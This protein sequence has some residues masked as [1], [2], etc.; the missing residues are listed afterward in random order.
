MID[1]GD[2]FFGL[3]PYQGF[4]VEI[5]EGKPSSEE[6]GDG[7]GLKT[8]MQKVRIILVGFVGFDF[9]D[10]LARKLFLFGVVLLCIWRIGR[11][12]TKDNGRHLR[13]EQSLS[14]LLGFSGSFFVES[15]SL[16]WLVWE[17][18]QLGRRRESTQPLEEAFVG[19]FVE[20]FW[21][22]N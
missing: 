7:D 9:D 4:G 1:K 15:P 14:F 20:T 12:M 18:K 13:R 11:R 17:Y 19:P 3:K 22:G 8:L 2:W 10:W 16:A 21:A 6:E 5:R